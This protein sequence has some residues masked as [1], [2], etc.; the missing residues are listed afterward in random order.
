METNALICVSFF[1]FI[2]GES[3]TCG[4]NMSHALVDGTVCMALADHITASM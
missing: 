1:Q 3:G 4:F 2:I